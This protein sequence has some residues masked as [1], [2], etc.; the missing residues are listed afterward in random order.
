MPFFSTTFSH[1]L[2]STEQLAVANRAAS[3]IKP[4]TAKNKTDLFTT[5]PPPLFRE[6]M[7]SASILHGTYFCHKTIL[8]PIKNKLFACHQASIV[9]FPFTYGLYRVIT[10]NDIKDATHLYGFKG[11]MTVL[12]SLSMLAVALYL[13][14]LITNSFFVECLDT[15]SNKL[16][17]SPSVAGATLMAAGSSMPEL[18]IAMAALF[19][20]GGRHSDVGIGTIV[21]SAVFNILVITGACAVIKTAYITL[22]AIVRDILFYLVSIGIMFYTFIDGRVELAESAALLA[23]YIVYIFVLRAFPGD[24]PKLQVKADPPDEKQGTLFVPARLNRIMTHIIAPIMGDTRKNYIRVFLISI[25]AIMFIGKILVDNAVILANAI[26]IPPVIIGLT[27][28]AASTSAPDL[29]SSMAAVKRGQ[30]DMAVANAVGSNIFDILVGLG[31]P[32]LISLLVTKKTAITVKSESLIESVLILVGTVVLL[33]I[34][35]AKNRKLGRKAGIFLL[36]I[37]AGYIAWIIATR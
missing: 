19:T 29:F 3:R 2:F 30:G 17:L 6:K 31:L 28:L 23:A 20:H 7:Q 37:Y 5:N 12:T 25:A 26:G 33:F 10:I 16:K 36:L 13:L 35:L 15:F 11:K 22:A 14:A 1:L 34:F 4:A 18:A 27:I 32:W 9:L 8:C 21:G 24:K